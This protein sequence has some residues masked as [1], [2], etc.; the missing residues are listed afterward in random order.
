MAK[1][2]SKPGGPQSKN[3]IPVTKR[4]PEEAKA[5]RS[6]GGKARAKQRHEQA[7]LTQIIRSVLAMGYRKGAVADPDEIYTLEEAEKKNVPIQT[8]IVMQEVKKYLATGNTESRDWLF[9]YA[10]GENAPLPAFMEGEGAEQAEDGLSIHLIRGDK[11]QEREREEDKATR[12]EA[13]KATAEAL[14]AV[15][16]AAEEAGAEQDAQ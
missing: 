8:L 4:S 11:P 9:R 1:G 12:E 5:I 14:K 15:G 10:F 6:M 2:G 13:R 7:Q 16:Q 3:L